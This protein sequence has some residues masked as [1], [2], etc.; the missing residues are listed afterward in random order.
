MMDQHRLKSDV[1][2]GKPVVI[3]ITV[4][5]RMRHPWLALQHYRR[6]V[7]LP[8]PH[9]CC[10]HSKRLAFQAHVGALLFPSLLATT[11]AEARHF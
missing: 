1:R 5:G 11:D 2:F 10:W 6:A 8:L 9:R 4:H 7:L 3:G